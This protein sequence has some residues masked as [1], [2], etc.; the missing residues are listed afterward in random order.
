MI[1]TAGYCVGPLDTGHTPPPGVCHPVEIL[2]QASN[3]ASDYGNKFGEPV[4]VLPA[5]VIIAGTFPINGINQLC[6]L[7]V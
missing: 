1:G 6:L 5:L 7:L 2:I 4:V 3:G